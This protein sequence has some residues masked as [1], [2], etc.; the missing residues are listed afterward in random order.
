MK[1]WTFFENKNSRV[2]HVFAINRDICS[3]STFTDKYIHRCILWSHPVK[4]FVKKN[5][6]P[7]CF[8]E[9]HKS[10]TTQYTQQHSTYEPNQYHSEAMRHQSLQLAVNQFEML[11]T[12]YLVLMWWKLCD[13]FCFIEIHTCDLFQVSLSW[14]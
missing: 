9:F 10:Q 1:L 5:L 12:M 7:T 14:F 6:H 2:L 11:S 13:L 4:F 8:S 3:N